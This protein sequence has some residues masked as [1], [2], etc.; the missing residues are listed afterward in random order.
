MIGEWLQNLDSWL[1]SLLNGW[2]CSLL[3]PVMEAFSSRTW[4]IALLLVIFILVIWQGG[5]QR[6]LALLMLLITLGVSDYVSSSIV[7]KSVKR[8]RPCN[9]IGAV[10]YLDNNLGWVMTPAEV[11]RSWKSSYSFPSSHAANGMAVALWL[12]FLFKRGRLWWLLLAF[13]IGYSR[14]YLGVHYPTD[15]LGGFLLGGLLAWLAIYFYDRYG[16]A[17]A[18]AKGPSEG[19][20]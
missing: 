17:A 5:K 19:T 15:I 11:G 6:R 14:I 18:P 1:F 16:P 13:G 10:H 2:H 4:L 12:G 20:E 7:K 3:D 8:S 9:Q